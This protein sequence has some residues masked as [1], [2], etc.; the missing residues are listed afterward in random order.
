MTKRS[1]AAARGLQ[2]SPTCGKRV[3]G[4]FSGPRKA[5]DYWEVK[6]KVWFLLFAV[7]F[8][9]LS[10]LIIVGCLAVAVSHF[11]SFRN[12]R[13]LKAFL[14]SFAYLSA[15]HLQLFY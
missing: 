1:P 6:I 14:F 10:N 5:G 2:V 11:L 4:R 8:P 15:G 3:P 9:V 12:F 7:S 13:I